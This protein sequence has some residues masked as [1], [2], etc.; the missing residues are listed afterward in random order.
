MTRNIFAVIFQ[1]DAGLRTRYIFSLSSSIWPSGSW[2]KNTDKLLSLIILRVEKKVKMK[3]DILYQ[4][5][6]SKYLKES[7]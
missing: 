6:R 5:I 1:R 4:M 3:F 2:K 7:K